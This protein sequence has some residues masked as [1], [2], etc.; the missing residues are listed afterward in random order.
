MKY[1]EI[2][3]IEPAPG[4]FAYDADYTILY[5]LGL[6]LGAAADEL[7]FV[8]ERQLKAMPTMAVMMSQGAGDFIDKGGIDYTRIVHGEQ[9]LTIHHPLPAAATMTSRS[10]I[11]SVIDK[12]AAKGALVNVESTIIDAGTGQRQATATMTLFCR[13]D[14][15]FGGPSDGELP[16]HRVPDRPHDLEVSIQTMPQ[17]AAIYR[18]SG[19]RNPLHIDPD[20]ATAVGFPGPILHGLC[21]Y[22]IAARAILRACCDNDPARIARLDARF[23]S[24]VFPGEA[25]ATRIWRDGSQLSFECVVAERGATVIRNGICQLR[26]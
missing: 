8:Y 18:L 19:D 17:Q 23:S 2:L 20:M 22:G 6:G 3:S 24:P 26:D 13:G 1:P 16:L 5:N 9:R 21:S 10:R 7:P 15:G 25:I 12:G 4:S 14:G 11:V